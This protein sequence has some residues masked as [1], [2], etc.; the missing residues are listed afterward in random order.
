[1]GADGQAQPRCGAQRGGHQSRGGHGAAVV[2]QGDGARVPQHA[3]VRGVPALQPPCDGGR[4]EHPRLG[5]FRLFPQG[6]NGLRGVERRR[7]VGH[8]QQAGHAA[9]RCRPAP[10]ENV[11]L[12]RLA[13]VAQVD[14]HVHQ[15]GRGDQ[16][17]RVQRLRAGTGDGSPG[18]RD[19]PAGNQQVTRFVRPGGRV[20]QPGRAD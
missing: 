3:P 1:M 11:L 18:P 12:F 10:G 4:D 8:A 16:A 17:A 9:G 19:F 6:R 14:V 20:D 5:G 7:G 2:A 13:G 15:P